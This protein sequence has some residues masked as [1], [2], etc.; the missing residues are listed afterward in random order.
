MIFNSI[1]LNNFGRFKGVQLF[2]PEI[3]AQ[4]NVVL[5]KA[6]NDRGK[7][8][9]FNAINFAMYGSKALPKDLA[10]FVSLQA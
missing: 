2:Q 3:T 9:L 5:I 6:I 1:E 4:R 10:E 8:T 7:T